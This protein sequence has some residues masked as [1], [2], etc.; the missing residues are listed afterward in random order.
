[1]L[2]EALAQA[3]SG[4][5]L[6]EPQRRLEEGVLAAVLDGVEADVALDAIGMCDAMAKRDLAEIAGEPVRR[7]RPISARPEC[8]VTMSVSTG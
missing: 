7:P 1:M 5:H 8:E 2:V 3:R 6:A 4:R